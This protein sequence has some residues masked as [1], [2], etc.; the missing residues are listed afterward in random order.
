MTELLPGDVIAKRKIAWLEE[1]GKV[2]L[3]VPKFSDG[4]FGRLMKRLAISSEAKVK[5]DELGSY[6]WHRLDG[7]NTLMG[8]AAALEEEFGDKADSAKDRVGLFLTKL[9]REGWISLLK[10]VPVYEGGDSEGKAG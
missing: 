8:I 3:L 1:D 10:K 7:K 9:Y 4:F 5:L 2:V 6:V